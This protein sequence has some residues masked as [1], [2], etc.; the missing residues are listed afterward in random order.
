MNTHTD[1]VSG[2]TPAVSPDG[3]LATLI[4]TLIDLFTRIPHT[5]LAMIPLL[6]F[7]F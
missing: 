2:N 3:H 6:T 5:P 4:R 1:R 7:Y